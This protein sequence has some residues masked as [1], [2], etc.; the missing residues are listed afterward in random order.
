MAQPMAPPPGALHP[1]Q[2]GYQNAPPLP[3][4]PGYRRAAPQVH[5][6]VYQYGHPVQQPQ[7]QTHPYYRYPVQPTYPTL[8]YPGVPSHA[9]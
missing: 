7:P 8:F 6:Q 2:S 4:A 5:P 9:R 1:S 3:P